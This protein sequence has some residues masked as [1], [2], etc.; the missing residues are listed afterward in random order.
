MLSADRVISRPSGGLASPDT[1][2]AALWMFL[3]WAAGDR[4]SRSLKDQ[5]TMLRR[6]WDICADG[7]WQGQFCS[8]SETKMASFEDSVSRRA[9]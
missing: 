6:G 7:Q 9:G 4:V 3:L 1:N 2:P 5:E 8:S